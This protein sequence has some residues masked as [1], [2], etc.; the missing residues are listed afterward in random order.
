MSV[1]DA[2][3]PDS[4]YRERLERAFRSLGEHGLAALVVVAA[5]SELFMQ[6]PNQAYGR[7]LIGLSSRFS[8]LGLVLTGDQGLVVIG[9][10]TVDGEYLRELRPWLPDV[11]TTQ[12]RLLGELV[13]Q[14][15]REREIG[16]GRIGL[17]GADDL[18]PGALG[19]LIAEPGELRFEPAH[20]V[21]DRLRMI[22]EPDEI[23]RHRRAAAL[24]DTMYEVLVDQAGWEGRPVAATQVDME[25]AAR[26]AGAERA[27]CWLATGAA[28]KRIPF[29]DQHLGL[30]FERDQQIVCGTYAVYQGYFGHAIRMGFKGVPTREAERLY[31]V[32]RASQE[33]AMAAVRPGVGTAAVRERAE[34]VLFRAFPA[35]PHRF[36][37]AH[38]LGLAYSEPPTE[39]AFPQPWSLSLAPARTESRD[40]P[41]AP[42][43]VLEIHPNLRVPGLGYCAIGD[44]LLVTETGA[45]RLTRFPRDHFIAD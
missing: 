37:V 32:V 44:M 38:F 26:R 18:S 12:P 9:P 40:L 24:V 14:I 33:A 15:L 30:A 19:D 39:Q 8:P 5:P 17:I 10:D 1:V 20:E 4:R 22:K 25:Y 16:R 35:D 43:M 13:R 2:E 11:R 41:L 27:T 3:L 28:P 7:Y 6:A 23:A 36:R 34:E 31:E 45:E 21:I 42:G 29:H